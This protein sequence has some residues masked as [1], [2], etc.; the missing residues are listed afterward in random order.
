MRTA[1]MILILA[2][3]SCLNSGCHFHFHYHT[4]GRQEPD[5]VIEITEPGIQDP[6]VILETFSDGRDQ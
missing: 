6:E 5:T 2:G 4:G 3:V 1:V